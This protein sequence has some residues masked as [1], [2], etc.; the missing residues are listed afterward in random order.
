MW[1]NRVRRPCLENKWLFSPALQNAWEGLSYKA[2]TGPGFKKLD[3]VQPAYPRCQNLVCLHQKSMNSE[4]VD[5]EPSLQMHKL[6]CAHFCVC[7]WGGG[8][9]GGGQVGHKLARIQA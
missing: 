5:T 7:V 2:N 6:P 9:G 8:G 3:S 4:N 1:P